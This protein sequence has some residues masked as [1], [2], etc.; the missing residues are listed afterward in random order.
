MNTTDDQQLGWIDF[1][2]LGFSFFAAIVTV[3]VALSIVSFQG[4]AAGE[5]LWPLPGFVL[6][7]WVLLGVMGFI[8]TYFC[9]RRLA[10]RWLQAMWF[11][12]GAF[13]PLIILGAFSIGVVV[14]LVFVLFLISSTI[15]S[16][17]Q[18]AKWLQ[19]LGLMLL[20]GAGN[21]ILLLIII[22]LGNTY[23]Q[24]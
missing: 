17:R 9:I 10:V 24:L 2:A 11:I 16:I 4:Q 13:I 6:L 1:L 23:Y 19:S 20:G 21:L 22:A 12:T 5:P 8:T 3:W 7:D 14:L 18:K 15:V